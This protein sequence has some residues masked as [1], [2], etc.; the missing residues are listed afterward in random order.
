[1]KLKGLKFKN[2]LNALKKN[3]SFILLVLILIIV[4]VI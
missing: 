2:I 3:I 4:T 1:M